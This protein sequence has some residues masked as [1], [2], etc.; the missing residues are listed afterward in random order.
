MPF[1]VAECVCPDNY[2]GVDCHSHQCTGDDGVTLAC[3]NGGTCHEGVGTVTTNQFFETRCECVPPFGGRECEVEDP[4]AGRHCNF[5]GDC[6][7]LD[8]SQTTA[9]C[10]CDAARWSGDNCENEAC[11]DDV[12]CLNGGSCTR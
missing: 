7:Y 9:M 5:R 4:C 1:V 10:Q 12:T 6:R 11:N 3:Q 2:V 8:D